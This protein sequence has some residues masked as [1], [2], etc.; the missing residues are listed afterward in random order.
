MPTRYLKESIKTSE[1]I[2][3]LSWFEEVLFYRLIVSVDDFGRYDGRASVIK[4]MLFPLKDNVS[5]KAIESAIVKLVR[6]H[7]IAVYERNGKRFL[8]LPSWNT[9]QTAPRAVKSKYPDPNEEQNDECTALAEHMHSNCI[10]DAEHM[11]STCKAHAEQMLPDNRES[12][13]DNRNRNRI[14]NKLLPEAGTAASGPSP[15]PPVIELTLNT[16][17]PYGVCREDVDRWVTLFPAV[18]VMQELR[19]MCAWLDGNPSRRKTAS[20]IKRFI[21]S[22]LSRTQNSAKPKSEPK[23]TVGSFKTDEF[24]E[25]ACKRTMDEF[26]GGDT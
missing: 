14:N 18:D 6:V 20:G 16:G 25:A 10:A 5:V 24:F 4:S 7:L 15:Q 11:S 2:D 3:Q 21:T 1:T 8:H 12:I 17:E 13:I 22:W 26:L 9:H 23:E 19:N